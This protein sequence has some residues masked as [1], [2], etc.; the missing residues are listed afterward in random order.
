MRHL[1]HESLAVMESAFLHLECQV[2]PPQQKKWRDGY[3][4]RYV[5]QSIH[6]ALILKLARSISSLRAIDI[7]LS[8]GQLQEQATLHRVLDEIH[9]DISFLALALTTGNTTDLHKKYLTAFFAEEFPNPKNSLA[10]HKKPDMPPRRKIRSYSINIH[11]HQNPSLIHDVGETISSVYSGYIHASAPQ[12]MDM[13]GGKPAHF[14]LSGMKGTPRMN[15]YID[16]AWHR[17]YREL[18]SIGLI[19]KAFGDKE[20]NNNISQ[21]LTLFEE[22]SGSRVDSYPPSSPTPK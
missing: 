6:Q 16:D 13:Y 18:M 12:I 3:V 22:K 17:F 2:P 5:E 4:F 9:E 20:L 19:A 21:Y 11:D 14:Y 15:E 1:F 10:R 8:H 7:L